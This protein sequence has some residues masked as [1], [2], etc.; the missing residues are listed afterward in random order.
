VKPTLLEQV[1]TTGSSHL[2]ARN[3]LIELQLRSPRFWGLREVTIQTDVGD[4]K[5]NTGWSFLTVLAETDKALAK[6]P[7]GGGGGNN[8]VGDPNVNP[9][10]GTGADPLGDTGAGP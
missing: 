5:L 7:S 2:D 8:V 1:G 4:P 10:T 6:I 3:Q 9:F